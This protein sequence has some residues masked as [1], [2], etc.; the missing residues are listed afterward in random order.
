MSDTP[1]P[2]AKSG[3]VARPRVLS[4]ALARSDAEPWWWSHFDRSSLPTDYHY[5]L[6]V[7]PEGRPRSMW[8]LRFWRM[9]GGIT[10]AL[11]RSRSNGD[12]FITT[13]ECDWT[14]FVVAGWQTLT[15]MRRPRHVIVQFI[16]R[17]R[18][19]SLASR[20]KYVV[21][22]WCF[23][24]VDTVICSARSECDYYEE[25]FGWPRGKAAYVPFHT[26]P[27]FLEVPTSEGDY[28]VAAGRTFRDYDTLLDAWARVSSMPLVIVG[29]KGS[30]TPPPNVTVHRELPLAELTRIIAGSRI[31]VVPLEER[32]ISIGQ[33][34]ILQG[35]AMGKPVVVTKVNGTVDYIEHMDTGLLVPPRD[36][37]ALASSVELLQADAALR[38][39]LSEAGRRRIR[40]RHMMAHYI[41]AVSRIMTTGAR[42]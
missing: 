29:Y 26:D 21:M 1:R 12:A 10:A 5:A 35:M 19:A 11:W 2:T 15:G 31:V 34:V 6:V 36:P 28:A 37:A 25:A 8:S 13:G 4:L 7:D 9:V 18:T 17:E 30:R 24:S 42:E 41:T 40:E 27:S 39:R 23:S 33:M 32:R 38:L 20:L 3:A 14:S 16:M 22:R